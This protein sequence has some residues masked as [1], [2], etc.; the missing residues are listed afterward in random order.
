[1]SG[2]RKSGIFTSL[3][4][5]TPLSALQAAEFYVATQGV[6]TQPGMLEQPFKT[7]LKAASAA[8]PGD[9]LCLYE[10]KTDIQS[11]RFNL[12]WVTS[13]EAFNTFI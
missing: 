2:A 4:L 11:A 1:M 3:L 7:I 13:P 5:L 6:D 8:R 9:T 12:D 10:T